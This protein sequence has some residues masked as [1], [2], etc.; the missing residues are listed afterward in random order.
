MP[1]KKPLHDP[2]DDRLSDRDLL[3][4]VFPERVIERIEE[5]LRPLRDEDDDRE[6]PTPRG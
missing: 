1:K 3:R 6:P 4:E 2:N 5:E